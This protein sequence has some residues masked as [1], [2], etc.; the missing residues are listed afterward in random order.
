MLCV[1][2]QPIITNNINLALYILLI[3]YLPL[4]QYWMTALD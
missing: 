4:M 2:F 1:K 3:K